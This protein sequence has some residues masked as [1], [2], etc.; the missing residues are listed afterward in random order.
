MVF[1]KKIY[2]DADS[3]DIMEERGVE[4]IEGNVTFKDDHAIEVSG[5]NGTDTFSFRSAIITAGGSPLVIPIKG[6]DEI[7]YLTNE[8]IFELKKQPKNLTILGSGPIG[9]EMAQAFSLLGSKLTLIA[10]DPQI[11]I[12]DEP[13]CTQFVKDNLEGLGVTFHLGQTI[14][15]IHKKKM[16]NTNWTLGRSQGRQLK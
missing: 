9:V 6:L 10:L 16:A 7:P 3:P 4:I 14:H 12:R 13:K 5:K 15:N 1:V 8:T 11:L 2:E